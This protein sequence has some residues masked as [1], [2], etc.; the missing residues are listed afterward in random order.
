LRHLWSF[1][2]GK[3]HAVQDGQKAGAVV[4]VHKAGSCTNVWHVGIVEPALCTCTTAPAFWP[5]WTA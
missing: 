1:W 4:Q 5:Y 3:V 2:M